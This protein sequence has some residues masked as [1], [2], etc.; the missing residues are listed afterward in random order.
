MSCKDTAS[1]MF[2]ADVFRLLVHFIRFLEVVD[3]CECVSKIQVSQTESSLVPD[4]FKSLDRDLVIPI[5][6][7]VIV[8]PMIEI[9]HIGGEAGKSEFVVVSQEVFFG[10]SRDFERFF[11]TSRMKQGGDVS[12]LLPSGL[13]VLSALLP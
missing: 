1:T 4:F 9:G 10:S 8:G 5:G 7:P 13:C 6:L 3:R 12:D 2:S 11:V